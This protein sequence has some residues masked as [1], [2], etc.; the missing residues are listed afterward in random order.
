MSTTPARYSRGGFLPGPPVHVTRRRLDPC[1]C[2]EP[3][4]SF[5]D[6]PPEHLCPAGI[7]LDDFRAWTQ[8]CPLLQAESARARAA[9][10]SSPTARTYWVPGPVDP[11]HVTQ[12][13]LD[14]GIDITD[15]AARRPRP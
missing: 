9:V 3:L 7:T 11:E 14:R 2:G 6:G 5:D 10:T 12:A 15:L 8:R 13:D 1:T 4:Y